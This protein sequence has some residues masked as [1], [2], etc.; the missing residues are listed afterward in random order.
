VTGLRFRLPSI[1]FALERLRAPPTS[2]I[3]DNSQIA[4]P[5][6]YDRLDRNVRSRGANALAAIFRNCCRTSQGGRAAVIQTTRFTTIS[7][8]PIARAA[9]SSGTTCSGRPCCRRCSGFARGGTGR[10][11]VAGVFSFGRLRG[12]RCGVV[13]AHAGEECRH[14]GSRITTAVPLFLA[15]CRRRGFNV[16]RTD[17]R[18]WNWSASDQ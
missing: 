7:S 6:R 17:V 8:T 2:K 10:F 12:G 1:A 15:V 4:R 13:G 3:E 18:R 9:I 14:Q 16:E 5:I 11:K